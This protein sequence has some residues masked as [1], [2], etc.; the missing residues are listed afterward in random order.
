MIDVAPSVTLINSFML[1]QSTVINLF[2]FFVCIR[3]KM[4]Y[5]HRSAKIRE[6][7]VVHP[8]TTPRERGRENFTFKLTCAFQ[9]TFH[10][11]HGTRL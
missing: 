1:I 10:S 11:E 4:F 6:K 3:T 7:E 8:R 9:I 5:S 2:I